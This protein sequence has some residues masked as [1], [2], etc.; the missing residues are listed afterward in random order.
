MRTKLI[1]GAFGLFGLLAI[2][3]VQL[4]SIASAGLEGPGDL[5]VKVVKTGSGDGRVS[6]DWAGIDCGSRC[7][8]S[9]SMNYRF[10]MQADPAAGSV[11]REWRVADCPERGDC[12]E[13]GRRV[14]E[15]DGAQRC[16]VE[17]Q[18]DPI[19]VTVVFDKRRTSATGPAP[20]VPCLRGDSSKAALRE[21]PRHCAF[22][23][24]SGGVVG[25]TRI[26]WSHWGRKSA[27]GRGTVRDAGPKSA[28][29]WLSRP[30]NVCGNLVFT[31]IQT[32]EGASGGKGPKMV[33]AA[34]V[35]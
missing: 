23:L 27:I 8:G 17:V 6:S 1:S 25:A 35:R 26:K 33:L 11:V 9:I 10:E 22:A 18:F 24:K 30:R 28:K 7:T 3:A 19:R 29:F 21:E 15:C 20:D 16:Q 12:Q 13:R 4:P 5:S 32:R 34:C 2:F 14:I 31:R